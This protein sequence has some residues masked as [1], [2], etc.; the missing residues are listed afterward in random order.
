M[1]FR[2]GFQLKPWKRYAGTH[3]EQSGRRPETGSC[4]AIAESHLNGLILTR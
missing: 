4:S 1:V 2:D 3:A